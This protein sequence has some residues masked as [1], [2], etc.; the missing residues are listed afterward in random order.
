MTMEN[1]IHCLDNKMTEY[2]L[3]TKQLSSC[4]VYNCITTRNFKKC[5][6]IDKAKFAEYLISLAPEYQFTKLSQLGNY[7]LEQNLVYSINILNCENN[8]ALYQ[9]IAN[10][11]L[12]TC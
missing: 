10:E 8:K 5:F 1:A 12:Y 3:D 6:S 4:E 2:F 7:L 11:L 9:E